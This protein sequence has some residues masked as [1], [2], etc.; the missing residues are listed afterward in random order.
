MRDEA[1]VLER[2]NSIP[3]SYGDALSI[4]Q[5]IASQ[6][7][8]EFIH[9]EEIIAITAAV[10]RI[11][12]DD[13]RSTH[14]TPAFDTSAMDGI[15]VSSKLT[16]RAT[17]SDPVTLC[18]KGII[19]AGDQPIP[20]A[21]DWE[22][23]Y[24]PCVEIMT[25][26]PFPISTS[27]LPFDAC[28]RVE[29]TT[30]CGRSQ[31]GHQ[32]V[33]IVKPAVQNQNRRFSGADFRPHDLV[34]SKGSL[35]RA[36]HIMALTSL[37]INHIS[38]YKRL[39]I[40]IFSTGSELLSFETNQDDKTRTR[41]SNGPYIQ[42]VLRELGVDATYYGIIKDD[43]QTF[44][45]TIR[46]TLAKSPYD[47][48]ITTGAVSMGKF[49][50]VRSGLT[51]LKADVRLHKVAIR[52]GHPVLFALVPLQR[53]G[54][55]NGYATPQTQSND[56]PIHKERKDDVPFF[57]LPGN[58]MATVVCLRFLVI[59]YL[60]FL[61]GQSPELP[62]QVRLNTTG[63]SSS[64]IN[65]SKTTTKVLKKPEHLRMFWH[66]RVRSTPE[67][68]VFEAHEDQGSSKI[69]A[70]LNANG[71]AVGLEGIDQVR[72]GDVVDSLPLLPLSLG[73]SGD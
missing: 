7:L 39:R 34:V 45:D 11:C 38:V 29:D 4:L 42:A 2:R 70:L 61:H 51:G 14:Q 6:R 37:G 64:H 54:V 33:K 65:G 48:I 50:F 53:E 31:G 32:L 13:Y 35:I 5:D 28:I 19:A 71:W 69:K 43:R 9:D 52:P 67:G 22:D 46:S 66:G 58:P 56:A 15:A 57:G 16:E 27:A 30:P 10:G 63:K 36:Q 68:L 41:D 24:L 73:D 60:R 8:K 26:A 55:A 18:I 21:S 47:A 44:E 40:G 17:P 20:T 25:G 72:H 1:L 49:D 62:T 12:R 23:G 59:P 3:I